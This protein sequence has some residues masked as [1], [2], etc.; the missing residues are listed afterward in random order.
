MGFGRQ[1]Y[2][3]DTSKPG[4]QCIPPKGKYEDP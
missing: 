2:Q 3:H 4:V 1:S